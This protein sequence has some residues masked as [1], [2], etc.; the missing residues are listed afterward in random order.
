[1]QRLWLQSGVREAEV[2]VT[3]DLPSKY[4]SNILVAMVATY[5]G[6]YG[7]Q[8][9]LVCYVCTAH[10]IPGL[11]NL[12]HLRIKPLPL[13]ICANQLT[14]PPFPITV[15]TS[16]LHVPIYSLNLLAY[17]AH[18]P[19]QAVRGMSVWGY[20]WGEMPPFRIPL[21]LPDLGSGVELRA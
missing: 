2:R 7:G 4:S 3:R 6:R 14:C 13:L 18:D 8:S 21:C 19:Y 20:Y 1:M 17:P 16:F 5:V 12:K 11:F 10:T 9:S 15:R